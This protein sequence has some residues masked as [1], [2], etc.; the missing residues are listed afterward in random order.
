M[1]RGLLEVHLVQ[2]KGLSGTDFLGKI[3]PYVIVQY[4]SQERKSSTARD[5]GRNPSWNEVL[6]FQINSSAANVQDKLVLRIMDHDNFSSDDFLGQA[7]INVTDLISMGMESG[8]SR[9]N[10]AK[11]RVVTADNSYHGEIKI[12]ITFTAAKVDAPSQVEEDGGQVGGWMHSVREQK[13]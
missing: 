7:T 1:A 4:R 13:V 3:D 2:A 6:R 11:Y 8:T 10:P 12:G 9:L 5:A